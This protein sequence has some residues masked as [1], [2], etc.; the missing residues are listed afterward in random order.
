M[1]VLVWGPGKASG[2]VSWCWCSPRLQPLRLGTWNGY[3]TARRSAN[4]RANHP[5][6]T[7]AVS[8]PEDALH[9]E[10]RAHCPQGL[11]G[12]SRKGPR[13]CLHWAQLLWGRH[14]IK[15]MGG[16]RTRN[17][18]DHQRK[19]YKQIRGRPAIDGTP[20]PGIHD[21]SQSNMGMSQT[22]PPKW[23]SPSSCEPR[24]SKKIIS[25]SLSIAFR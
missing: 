12:Q 11:Q 22:R 18:R 2:Q 8:L 5:P 19:V 7:S 6:V 17:L 15:P 14:E 10:Q 23:L 20:P 25:R 13:I 3:G 21:R 24:Q 9:Q 16:C 1:A 4:R